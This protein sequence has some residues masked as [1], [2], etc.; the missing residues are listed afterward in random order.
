MNEEN[1]IELKGEDWMEENI[2]THSVSE[3][4]SIVHLTEKEKSFINTL[5]E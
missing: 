2:L 5:K 4:V 3:V 1:Y